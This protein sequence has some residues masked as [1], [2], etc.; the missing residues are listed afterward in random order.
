MSLLSEQTAPGSQIF[1]GFEKMLTHGRVTV[2]RMVVAPS[3]PSLFVTLGVVALV[4]WRI[5]KRVRRMIGRQRLSNWRPWF[6]V[7]FFPLILALLAFGALAHPLNLATLAAGVAVGAGLGLYGLHLTTF[8]ATSQGLFY[9]PNAH[10][11]IALSLLLVGRI[12]FR[13]AQIY[14]VA[15]ADTPLPS[16]F[17][18][19][20][21]TL[22]IFGTLAG[23]YIVY[24]IGLLRWRLRVESATA[25]PPSP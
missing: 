7:V 24:A 19:S 17:V 5:Y 14:M 2:A 22:A 1:R 25:A 16:D 23:Y 18:R 20:P 9:T 11:G 4:A 15:G 6:T 13:I 21:L 8:E 3:H 12:V 10:L